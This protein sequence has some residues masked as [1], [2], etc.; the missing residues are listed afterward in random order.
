VKGSY[1]TNSITVTVILPTYNRLERLRRVLAGLE[2]QYYPLNQFDVIVVSDGSTDGTNDYLTA[3]PTPLRLRPLLQSN[4]GVAAAR[5]HG[6]AHAHSDLVLFIDDDVVPEPHLILE[7]VRTHEAKGSDVVVLGPMLTPRNFALSPWVLWEQEMLTKQY[8][9][10]LAGQWQPTARQFYTGNTSLARHHLQA[11]GGFDP[12]FRRA[13]DVELAYRLADHG[14]CFLFNPA[15]VGYHYAERSFSA[16]LE[17]PYAYGRNDVIFTFQ[18]GQSWLLPTIMR[19]FH[20]RHSL[21]KL[22]THLCLDRPALSRLTINGLSRLA[23]WGNQLKQPILSRYAYSGIFNLCHYQGIA[24]QLGGRDI[25]F[26]G[27][28]QAKS[29]PASGAKEQPRPNRPPINESEA[30][31]VRAI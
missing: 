31:D 4:Q 21:V 22:V 10:M 27:V 15:A 1:L 23:Q 20:G 8:E 16:W 29:Q 7:H 24:D 17:I 14:L 9:R 11:A 2:Q 26:I 3:V 5:N 19:E 18:K 28:R 30:T 13:E 6:V 12:N 25:F